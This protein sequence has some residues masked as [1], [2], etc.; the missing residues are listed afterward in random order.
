AW[1]A[2]RH[3]LRTQAV[4]LGRLLP[5]SVLGHRMQSFVRRVRVGYRH[6][7]PSRPLYDAPSLRHPAWYGR[8]WL[9]SGIRSCERRLSRYQMAFLRG[10]PWSD[11]ML[12]VSAVYRNC[13]FRGHERLGA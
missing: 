6:R 8:F 9:R 3:W 1:S 7:V 2:E 4:W 10:W 12:R 5:D 13:T 11:P